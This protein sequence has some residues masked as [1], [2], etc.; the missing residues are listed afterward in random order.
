[1]TRAAEGPPPRRASR[2]RAR[3]RNRT[4]G[5]VVRSKGSGRGGYPTIYDAPDDEELDDDA[6]E[7]EEDPDEEDHE[8][9]EDEES[10]DDDEDDEE[11]EEW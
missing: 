1:L 2:K 11:S 5:P 9:D 8:L 3:T 10:Y 4:Q 6:D 7:D